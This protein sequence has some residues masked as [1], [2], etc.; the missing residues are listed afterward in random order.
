MLQ[1]I[2]QH[3][4]HGHPWHDRIHWY[5]T[6]GSTNDTARQ[7]AAE[8]APGGTV[9]LAGHQTNGHGRLGRSF[10]SPAGAGVYVSCILRPD[11]L[12]TQLMHLT[13]AAAVA[14]AQAVERASGIHPG[15]KWTND[16]VIGS[17]KLG[18]I[19]TSL[20]I[21]PKTGRVCSAIIG[22][23]INCLQKA[24]DFPPE[25][26]G[27]ACSLAM[28]TEKADPAVL[29]GALVET[30][31]RMDLE[32]LTKKAAIMEAYRKNCITLGKAVSWQVGDQLH[33]GEAIDLEEDGS[34]ILRMSDGSMQTVA[35]GEVS[36]RGMYGYL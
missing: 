3:I 11:C 19:L 27:I 29:A 5:D 21:D 22:I 26:Q 35:F 10:C 24:A 14:S 32:L 31:Y 36:V 9:I 18:G 20:Q 33:H 28:H 17:K 23:G 4:P 13:C 30:L 25:L 2:L 8:G 12:P 34:L 1:R 15:I 6:I 16:L 7:M